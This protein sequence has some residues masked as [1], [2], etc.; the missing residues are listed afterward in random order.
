MLTCYGSVVK[1]WGSNDTNP[2]SRQMSRPK[3][4]LVLYNIMK[5]ANFGFLQR[6]ASA[7][8]VSEI[9]IVGKR[10]FDI[11]GACG[12]AKLTRKRQ[13]HN[14]T[15]AVGYLHGQGADICGIEIMPNAIPVQNHPFEKSTAFMVGNEGSGLTQTQNDYCDFHVYIPQFGEAECIN[16][17]VA[18]G[19]ALSHFAQWAGFQEAPRCENKFIPAESH[20]S[21]STNA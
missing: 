8:G 14:L 16:V 4:Y 10:S 6:T 17:N 3:S 2:A 9:I 12:T 13:F 5:H 20:Q 7:F 11:G 21:S 18:A 15:D 19:I 1:Q